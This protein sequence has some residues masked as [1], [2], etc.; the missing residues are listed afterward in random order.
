MPYRTLIGYDTRRKGY[1]NWKEEIHVIFI[2]T[3]SDRK[4]G[5][6][7]NWRRP[8]GIDSRAPVGNKLLVLFIVG[9]LGVNPS[10]SSGT[11]QQKTAHG[12]KSLGVPL[13]VFFHPG[14]A[15]LHAQ[16]AYFNLKNMA[17]P[18]GGHQFLEIEGGVEIY[19]A[20]IRNKIRTQIVKEVENR[21]NSNE[22][23]RVQ[24]QRQ[25]AP[26]SAPMLS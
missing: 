20:T 24:L 1:L 3:Q 18:A 4:I 17:N 6:K 7:Q 26:R 15:V 14:F 22:A 2:S 19:R 21:A 5:V 11:V 8:K 23:A 10:Y 9:A 12:H 16:V 25:L 13:R